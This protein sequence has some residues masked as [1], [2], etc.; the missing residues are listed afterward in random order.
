MCMSIFDMMD[1]KQ[2]EKCLKEVGLLKELQ[3]L[4]I[5][6]EWASRGDLKRVLKRAVASD[7]YLSEGQIWEYMRQLSSALSY[8]QKKRIM[9]RDVKPANIFLAEDGTLKLGDLGLG[10]FFSSQ[11][12]EAFSK[13]G[14]PL[15]MSPEVLKGNGY[16]MKSDVWSLGCVFY[17]LCVRRSPFKHPEKNM[18]LYDLFLTISKGQYAPLPEGFSADLRKTVDGMLTLEVEKRMSME[19]VHQVCEKMT[20]GGDAGPRVMTRPSPFLVMDD[21]VEKLKIL[22]AEEYFHKPR[23]LPAL[24]RCYFAMPLDLEAPLTQFAVMAELMH[25]LA[26]LA[27]D[28]PG[29]S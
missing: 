9:H 6:L 26:E 14:T 23:N 7:V 11:T 5:I 1:Q 25:W 18:S 3:H 2:R 29:E 21:I 4:H 24:H 12:M 16:D 8:M 17:E 15:Y 22:N 20:A 10:R 27:R 28:R 19:E 13:V